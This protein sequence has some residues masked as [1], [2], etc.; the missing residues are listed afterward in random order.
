MICQGKADKSRRNYVRGWRVVGDCE[1]RDGF[2]TPLSGDVLV[3][4]QTRSSSGVAHGHASPSQKQPPVAAPLARFQMIANPLDF[5]D[6][7]MP[8]LVD[9]IPRHLSHPP[10]RREPSMRIGPTHSHLH[11]DRRRY[12]T[13]TCILDSSHI[14]STRTAG[15][16]CW[17][18]GGC[19]LEALRVNGHSSL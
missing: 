12:S 16:L 15:G 17:S 14:R 11:L 13:N 3:N 4:F 1:P 8:D 9:M 7:A 2:E 10:P 6:V 5:G 19:D 18:A